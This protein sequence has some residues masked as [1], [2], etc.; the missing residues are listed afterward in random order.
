[1]AKKL[2]IKLFA[3]NL[4]FTMSDC[5]DVIADLGPQ[6]ENLLTAIKDFFGDE[7]ENIVGISLD[8]GSLDEVFDLD[9]HKENFRANLDASYAFTKPYE[10][11][12]ANTLN[13]RFVESNNFWQVA[14]LDWDPGFEGN[15]DLRNWTGVTFVVFSE[16]NNPDQKFDFEN[17]M[18]MASFGA[19]HGYMSS[20]KDDGYVTE[21]T[22]VVFH[23][24]D[25]ERVLQYVWGDFDGSDPKDLWIE[26]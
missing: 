18:K 25:L 15:P 24:K 21:C 8:D 22:G 12:I 1:M 19:G 16:R 3:D 23:R 9:V 7:L 13:D 26:E 2:N 4:V 10:T 11:R 17:G 20:I 5:L 6:G 14:K